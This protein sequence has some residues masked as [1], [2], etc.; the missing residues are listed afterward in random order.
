[1]QKC[2]V[3]LFQLPQ[4]SAFGAKNDVTLEVTVLRSQPGKARWTP[5]LMSL[6]FLTRHNTRY[7]SKLPDRL[8]VKATYPQPDLIILKHAE[9]QF[10]VHFY[11]K[12]QSSFKFWTQKYDFGECL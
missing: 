1:M 7:N 10:Q 6:L 11:L 3:G 9:K 5:L 2:D 12:R 8:C 4:T